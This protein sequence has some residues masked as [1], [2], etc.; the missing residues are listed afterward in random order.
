MRL[1][2]IITGIMANADA[3]T[4]E[5]FHDLFMRKYGNRL[6]PESSRRV[7]E[8]FGP[9]GVLWKMLTMREYPIDEE[10]NM[11]T[12]ELR[13]DP[14]QLWRDVPEGATRRGDYFTPQSWA[15]EWIKRHDAIAKWVM[16]CLCTLAN[17]SLAGQ[18]G[19]YQCMTMMYPRR[20]LSPPIFVM[21]HPF[22]RKSYIS[23]LIDTRPMAREPGEVGNMWQLECL[24]KENH[25]EVFAEP[26]MVPIG[27]DVDAAADDV[28][29]DG[30]IMSGQTGRTRPRHMES[31]MR[32]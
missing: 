17:S 25:H 9:D 28:Q 10:W 7:G 31:R 4:M 26:G 27:T 16:Q 12:S 3:P 20:S 13:M 18:P 23:I 6:V 1:L 5:R 32:Y 29:Q 24:L 22:M 11:R 14:L 30:T 19:F 2:G 21:T 15:E 8:C